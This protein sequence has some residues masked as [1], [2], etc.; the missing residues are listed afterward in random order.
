MPHLYAGKQIWILPSHGHILKLYNENG[1]WIDEHTISNQ[2][3]STIYKQ[4]HYEG[5]N[6][7]LPKSLPKLRELFLET[8]PSGN[9]YVE[10]LQQEVK[11]NHAYRFQK[12]WELRYYYEDT[13]IDVVLQQAVT[14]QR[15]V[16]AIN[17]TIKRATFEGNWYH[18]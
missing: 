1:K 7:K 13:I 9:D 12:I 11:T 8:F 15:T 5:M 6:N 14:Y 4:E 10:L 17:K 16:G 18:L 3:G 2:K